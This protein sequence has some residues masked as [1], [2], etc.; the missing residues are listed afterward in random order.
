MKEGGLGDVKFT[1]V[2]YLPRYPT[3][4]GLRRG[5]FYLVNIARAEEK[6]EKRVFSLQS[7]T[8]CFI[9]TP[10]HSTGTVI[11]IHSALPIP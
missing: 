1:L 7:L 11:S 8:L 3:D 2:S 9:S 6:K 10:S 4:L 5:E